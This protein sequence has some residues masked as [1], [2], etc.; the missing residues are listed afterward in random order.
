MTRASPASVPP[1]ENALTR[2]EWATAIK[3]MLPDYARVLDDHALLNN[4]AVCFIK[5]NHATVARALLQR[6]LGQFPNDA[7]ILSNMSLAC[8]ELG[9]LAEAIDYSGR[10]L[11]CKPDNLDALYN[12]GLAALRSG[13]FQRAQEWF[14]KIIAR[15]P[16]YFLGKI[17]HAL[18][19]LY[20]GDYANGWRDY[21]S[22]CTI[23]GFW[24]ET[25]TSPRWQG[26]SLTGK[27][28]VIYG[29]Q[30]YGDVIQFARFLPQLQA[31]ARRVVVTVRPELVRLL[32]L[33]PNL[34]VLP[35][36]Q[37]LPPHDCH[38]PIVSL[39]KH[40][41]ITLADLPG[42]MPYFTLPPTD[43][44]TLSPGYK[45]VALVW[46]GSKTHRRDHHRSL[47]LSAIAP[48]LSIP[49]ICWWSVQK[50][51]GLQDIQQLGWQGLINDLAPQ[52][53]DFYDLGQILQRMDL[54]LGV[55]TAPL[56]LAGAL[57]K[58]AWLITPACLDWRWL[59]QQ[60]TSPWYPS[61]RLFIQ[62]E[63]FDWPSTID[64]VAAALQEWRD[65]AR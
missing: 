1:A 43:K 34:H 10:A 61:L 27:T 26:E 18:P 40:F 8:K 63:M 58:P 46:Q 64:R 25:P 13:Q 9:L 5:L 32:Q 55:D 19:A 47:P 20:Q 21:E 6:A 37:A 14:E 4:L 2:G 24:F 15:A 59:Y 45:H 17:D 57:N 22:R 54:V 42:K 12:H 3:E 36:G 52:I 31:Q 60:S 30:G 23:P 39:A 50:G 33:I 29:E 28:I 51:E 16:N 53:N 65:A 7:N 44:L 38:C 11:V 41:N 48:L 35:R 56:H 62:H 49:G